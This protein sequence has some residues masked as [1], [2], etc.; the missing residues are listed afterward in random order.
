MENVLGI[1]SNFL[2]IATSGTTW[3]KSR[4]VI[5]PIPFE[6]T[7]SY[8]KGTSRGPAAILKASSYVEFYDEET[9]RDVGRDVGIATLPP[10][11]TGRK[12]GAAAL[13]AIESRAAGVIRSG[14]FLFSLGGEHT[15]TQALVRAHLARYPDLS[16]LQIDAHSDLRTAY[17]GSPWSHACVMAR[18]CEFLDPKR[19][20]QIGIRAQCEEEARFIVE[21]DITTLYAHQIRDSGPRVWMNRAVSKLSKNVYVTFDVD[22]L[23][24]SVMPATGTPEPNGLLWDETMRLLRLLASKRNVVGCDVVEFSPLKGLHYA[25]LAAAKLVSKMIN[26]FVP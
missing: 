18:I 12:K 15:V 4:V 10:L 2:G 3:K 24:P 14:K 6:Q 7:V 9:R 13:G 5:L 21:K 1:D 22:G 19:I 23:D 11:T 8:G 26:Y 16:V 20:V 17:Q 25:D